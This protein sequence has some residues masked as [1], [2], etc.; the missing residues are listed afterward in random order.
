[1]HVD[2]DTGFTAGVTDRKGMLTPPEHLENKGSLN[3]RLSW[4]IS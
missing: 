1:M 4:Y 3:K 2:H